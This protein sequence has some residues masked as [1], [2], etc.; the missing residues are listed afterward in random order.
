M[1]VSVIL[2]L[3]A[4]FLGVLIGYWIHSRRVERRRREEINRERYER[5]RDERGLGPDE[6]EL[7]E[8]LSTYL[9]APVKKHLILRNK[10]IFNSCARKLVEAHPE[11]SE[12]ISAL[13]I[14]LGFEDAR[15]DEPLASTTEI[16]VQA[17]VLVIHPD[18]GAVGA[19]VSSQEED[20][21]TVVPSGA[22]GV[23]ENGQSI[24]L[25]YHNRSGVFSF[26]TTVVS[27]GADTL[28]V[29]HSE[30]PEKLQRRRYYR[31]PIRRPAYVRPAGEDEPHDETQFLDIGGGGASLVNPYS[32]Y[33][34]GDDVEI[35]FS[36]QSNGTLSVAARVIRTSHGGDVIH[37]KYEHLRESTRD[38]IYGIMFSE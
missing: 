32:K 23:F 33:S 24:T 19:Y 9:E 8:E 27:V 18:Q 26:R 11:V 25:L 7:I 15:P 21:L 37:V 22:A 1:E 38:R 34:P 6:E 13:R 30:Q 20:A 3:L 12:A 28:R 31:Q 14:R 16:P 4:I 29:N 5:I 35:S 17:S 36:P 10:G 2:G